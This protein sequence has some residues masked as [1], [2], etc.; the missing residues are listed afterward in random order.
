MVSNKK[1]LVWLDVMNEKE[2]W[3]MWLL[4]DTV[5]IYPIIN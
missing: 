3:D 2:A 5:V 4:Y 1:K